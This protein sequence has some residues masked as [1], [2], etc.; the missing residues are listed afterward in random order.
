MRRLMLLAG[1]LAMSA[2]ALG[3]QSPIDY[4]RYALENGLTVFLVENHDVPVVTV[5]VW[6]NVGSRNER[7]G[8]SGFAHLFEHMM[9]Q[10]SAN[11]GKGEHFQLIERAG[12][13]MNGTT[14]EGRTNYFEVLPSNRLNLG[15]WLEADRMRSLAITDENGR[16]PTLRARLLRWADPLVRL[17]LLLSVLAHGH[18]LDGRSECRADRG[19]A[20]VLRSVLCAE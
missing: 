16:Q 20:G 11:V 17:H 9:F 10:G 3:A 19:R 1:G 4:E 2:G 13:N 15:L 14:N 5:N 6:Y 7:T 12:G 18:W 8:R